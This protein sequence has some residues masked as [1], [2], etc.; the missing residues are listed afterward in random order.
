[1]ENEER[2]AESNSENTA[3]TVRIAAD[4]VATIAG[5]TAADVAG[6]AGMSGGVAGGIAEMLGRKNMTKGVRV[7]VNEQDTSIDL[8]MIMEY[9]VSI[10]DVARKVQL[11]VKNAVEN[12]TGLN[13][14]SVNI[15]V[16]GIRFPQ[17]EAAPADAE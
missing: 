10:A 15:H 14:K 9:G 12:M 4:V 3:G 5:M 7:E 1:M 17:A 13:C 11:D 16:Q 2:L 6:V 8:Y